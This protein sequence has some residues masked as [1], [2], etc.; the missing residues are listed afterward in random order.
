MR[1][2][3]IKRDITFTK[4]N[5]FL[6]TLLLSSSSWKHNCHSLQRERK[7]CTEWKEHPLF[8]WQSRCVGRSSYFMGQET[9]WRKIFSPAGPLRTSLFVFFS[10]LCLISQIYLATHS[11][12]LKQA[13]SA[14]PESLIVMQ[15]PRPTPES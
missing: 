7:S 6:P 4:W 15:N 8:L 5:E 13:E 10:P 3:W 1:H 12:G 2:K 11:V 9:Q 14:S